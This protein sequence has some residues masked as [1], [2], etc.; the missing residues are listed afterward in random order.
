[1]SINGISAV[2]PP[3]IAPPAGPAVPP[4]GA[5]ASAE[6]GSSTVVSLSTTG[7]ERLQSA[8][9]G[10]RMAQGAAPATHPG[11]AAYQSVAS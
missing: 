10:D 7:L 5:P 9:A 2:L 3:A 8:P 11:V 1:M 6:V 4:A